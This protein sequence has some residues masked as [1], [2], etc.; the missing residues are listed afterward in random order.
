[1]GDFEPQDPEDEEELARAAHA[2]APPAV[3]RGAGQQPETQ[4]TLAHTPF[5]PPGDGDDSFGDDALHGDDPDTGDEPP[6]D[7][8]GAE[9]VTQQLQE[10]VAQVSAPVM[11][12]PPS[13]I[14]ML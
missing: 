9:V 3:W 8:H 4:L 7:P 10:F 11:C 5:P 2:G 6:V 12:A 13:R 14:A 1:M